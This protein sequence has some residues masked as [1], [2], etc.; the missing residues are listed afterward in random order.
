MVVQYKNKF[1]PYSIP[2]MK[3]SWFQI[4]F[5]LCHASMKYIRICREVDTRVGAIDILI[6]VQNGEISSELKIL[7]AKTSNSFV[8]KHIHN[9]VDDSTQKVSMASMKSSGCWYTD[10][11]FIASSI[12]CIAMGVVTS[13]LV[14][15]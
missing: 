6:P 4:F 1:S 3:C 10:V 12:N 15:M 8:C 9:I 14:G 5:S 13:C 11:F 2:I 7:K